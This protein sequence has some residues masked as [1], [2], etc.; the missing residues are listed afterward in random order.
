MRGSPSLLSRL[1]RLLTNLFL[2]TVGS[3]AIVA[4]I[5]C[6]VALLRGLLGV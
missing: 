6:A 5:I 3:I 1:T 2:F 4:F